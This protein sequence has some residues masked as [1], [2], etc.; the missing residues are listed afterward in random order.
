M[1]RAVLY[2]GSALVLAILAIGVAAYADDSP[3]PSS[4]WTRVVEEAR[5]QMASQSFDGVVAVQWRDVDGTHRAQMRVR[6]HAGTVEIVDPDRSVVSDAERVL[7]D[8]QAWTTMSRTHNRVPQLTPGKYQ[9]VRLP[10][11]RVAGHTTTRYEARHE[12]RVVERLF[13]QDARGLVLRREVLDADGR[14]AR[15]VSFMRVEVTP[16]RGTAPTTGAARAGPAPVSDLDE[17]F[18]DP[19]RAG[20]GFRLLGRW[21]HRDD[22]AQLHYSDGVLSVSVFEQPGRLA[23]SDLP[24]GGVDAE[25]NGHRARRYT[26]PAG[27]A[28]VFER[29]GVVY[30]CVGDATGSELAAIANDVSRPQQNRFERLAEMVVDPFRW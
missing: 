21:A 11:P 22:L 9:V 12:G 29:D 6:Q 4:E 26:L 24:S 10:G 16:E 18:H 27:E 5:E 20:E 25:V 28:W 17:P 15:A 19:S 13:V 3:S 1:R 30:T 7:L 14:V 23:W 8:G 2:A